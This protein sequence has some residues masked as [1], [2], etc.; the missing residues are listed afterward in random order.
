MSIADPEHRLHALVLA[1]RGRDAGVVRSLFHQVGIESTI[2]ADIPGLAAKLG[3]DVA[4][5]FGARQKF[6]LVPGSVHRRA[7]EV[8]EARV[9]QRVVIATSRLGRH[10]L[11]HQH[12]SL[13]GEEPAWFELEMNGVAQKGFNRFARRVPT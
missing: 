6:D 4:F 10:D 5:A 9:D 2:C 12:A 13:R 1:P 11:R 7:H 3:D 8:V